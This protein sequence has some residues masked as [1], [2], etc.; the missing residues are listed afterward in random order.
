MQVRPLP[1]Q[2]CG[3]AQPAER[4]NFPWRSLLT[5]LRVW[6]NWQTRYP[7]TVVGLTAR[8]GSTPVT[9]I[10]VDVAKCQTRQVEGLVPSGVQ[11]RLLLSALYILGA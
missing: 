9:R 6:R 10:A 2:K 4:G 1:P 11:V 5:F 8:A 3:V 7:Q